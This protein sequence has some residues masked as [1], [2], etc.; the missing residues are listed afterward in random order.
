MGLRKCK[1]DGARDTFLWIIIPQLNCRTKNYGVWLKDNEVK[2]H[3]TKHES[4]DDGY[5]CGLRFAP[6]RQEFDL[7]LKP[8]LLTALESN[9]AM[10]DDVPIA[11]LSD[12]RRRSPA[13]VRAGHK[14]ADGFD[15]R[16]LCNDNESLLGIAAV[17]SD[18][19][20]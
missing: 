14:S 11:V 4:P 9:G 12:R 1:W 17:D 6:D 10:G 16:A 13:G 20:T 8:L 15:P 19:N 3:P 7:V 5:R 18:R 2:C